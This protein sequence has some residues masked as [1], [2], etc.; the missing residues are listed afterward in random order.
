VYE[1]IAAAAN[2]VCCL[3]VINVQMR[4]SLYGCMLRISKTP[5]LVF[6]CLLFD[7]NCPTDSRFCSD[8]L[9]CSRQ[10]HLTVPIAFTVCLAVFEWA[11]ELAELGGHGCG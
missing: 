6:D 8:F 4:T 3:Y 5:K 1:C 10:L 9:W 11:V 2:I 7:L